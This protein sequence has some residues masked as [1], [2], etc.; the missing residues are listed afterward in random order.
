MKGESQV[1]QV[2]GFNAGE[3]DWPGP[4][5]QVPPSFSHVGFSNMV[6]GMLL[7]EVPRDGAGALIDRV[8]DGL[9]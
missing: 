9:E 8:P 6:I 1:S 4:H 3:G 7:W 5:H 2:K